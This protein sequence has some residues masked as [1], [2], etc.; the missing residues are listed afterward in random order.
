MIKADNIK[1]FRSQLGI[2]QVDLAKFL[3]IS[4]SLL[5]MIESGQRSVSPEVEQ[6]MAWSECPFMK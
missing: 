1:T 3:G 6:R 4:S 2:K 5:N